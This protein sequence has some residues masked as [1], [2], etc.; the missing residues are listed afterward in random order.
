MSRA[1]GPEKMSLST[2]QASF[3]GFFSE[4]QARSPVS[5]TR[6]GETYSYYPGLALT[7]VMWRRPLDFAQLKEID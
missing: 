2:P 1:T 4:E 7:G 5:M 6:S 3:R